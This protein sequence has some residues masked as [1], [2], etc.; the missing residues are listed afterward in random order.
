VNSSSMAVGNNQVRI[1][2]DHRTGR[3]DTRDRQGGDETGRRRAGNG[4]GTELK[5]EAVAL[6]PRSPSASQ[7][8]L[9]RQSSQPCGQCECEPVPASQV[10]APDLQKICEAEG[11][12]STRHHTRDK[13]HTTGAPRPRRVEWSGDLTLSIGEGETAQGQL[14]RRV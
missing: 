11:E 1:S 7:P 8:A 4:A 5:R 9:S 13:A 2:T 6:C 3:D 14:V 12:T 10:Q